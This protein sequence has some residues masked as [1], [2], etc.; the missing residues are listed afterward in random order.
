M[1]SYE[2]STIQRFTDDN[3][4]RLESIDEHENADEHLLRKQSKDRLPSLF[5]PI[6]ARNTVSGLALANNSMESP[7]SSVA[8]NALVREA[9]KRFSLRQNS[10]ISTDSSQTNVPSYARPK[11]ISQYNYVQPRIDTGLPRK[12]SITRRDMNTHQLGPT[13]SIDWLLLQQQLE[14]NKEICTQAKQLKFN[15]GI[16][17]TK[18]LKTLVYQVQLKIRQYLSLTMGP[19]EERYKIVV[20]I[21]VFPKTASGLFIGSRCLWNTATDKSIT[22]QMEGV[23]CNILI[24]AYLFYTDLGAILV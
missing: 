20:N 1:T 19:G 4:L 5:P 16:T 10:S 14:Q 6:T 7:R 13:R 9:A 8:V 24:V 22:I 12:E 23:D 17:Y 15:S 3:I 2:T 21:T 18:Q 11:R